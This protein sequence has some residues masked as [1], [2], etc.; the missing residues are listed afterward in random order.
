[1]T[2]AKDSYRIGKVYISSTN[3]KDAEER[4]TKAA[5][6]GQGGYVCVS[7]LRMIRYAGGHPDYAELMDASLMNFPDGKPLMW[8]AR[9]WGLSNVE[10]TN[11][12]A[13]FKEMLSNG[14][15]S[16]KHYLLGD[17]QDVLD[18]ILEKNNK[19]VSADTVNLAQ[20]LYLLRQLMSLII[21]L[22]LNESKHLEQMS[23]GLQCEHQNRINLINA[24]ILYCLMLLAWVSVELLGC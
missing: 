16:L 12:P 18:M 15:K 7:N 8:C 2:M 20:R 6:S 9:L 23:F 5:L 21:R 3:P 13:F 4:I 14:S 1:M 17:T 10:T 22:F 24:Y 11:G 19:F